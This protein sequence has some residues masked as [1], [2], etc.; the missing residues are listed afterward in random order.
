MNIYHS[1][2]SVHFFDWALPPLLGDG[3]L[4]EPMFFIKQPD[5]LLNCGDKRETQAQHQFSHSL[6][7][8]TMFWSYM[9][10][11]CFVK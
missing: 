5:S 8:F 10:T 4:N 1:L 11:D 9:E 6:P 3:Y 2:K 7:H